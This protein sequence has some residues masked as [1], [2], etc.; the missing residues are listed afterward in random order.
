MSKV[1]LRPGGP[2]PLRRPVKVRRWLIRIPEC[3]GGRFRSN[4]FAPGGTEASRRE[5]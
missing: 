3:R 4:E 2:E 5:A 1:R